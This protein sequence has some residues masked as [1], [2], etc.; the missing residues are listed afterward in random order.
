MFHKTLYTQSASQTTP[1]LIPFSQYFT[2]VYNNVFIMYTDVPI[3]AFSQN[4]SNCK[5]SHPKVFLGKGAL[6]I[7]SKFTGEHPRRSVI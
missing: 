6:K 7:N 5:S 2:F 1:A 3:S 4:F